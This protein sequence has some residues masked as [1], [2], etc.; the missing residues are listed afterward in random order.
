MAELRV[1]S[2]V[3]IHFGQLKRILQIFLRLFF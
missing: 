1:L 3:W 2:E